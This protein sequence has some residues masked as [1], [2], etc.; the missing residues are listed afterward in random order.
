[1]VASNEQHCETE[2]EG[3]ID[4]E[5]HVHEPESLH[6]TLNHPIAGMTVSQRLG[7]K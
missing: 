5:D 1:V 2:A 7:M 6:Q 3:T 4:G